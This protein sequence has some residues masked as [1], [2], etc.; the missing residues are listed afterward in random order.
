MTS[1][2]NICNKT[3]NAAIMKFPCCLSN[4]I[5]NLWFQSLACLTDI[6][7]VKL[8]LWETAPLRNCPITLTAKKS[9]TKCWS[10]LTVDTYLNNLIRAIVNQAI[11]CTRCLL[12]YYLAM[13]LILPSM[14]NTWQIDRHKLSKICVK[15]ILIK[16]NKNCLILLLWGRNKA[17]KF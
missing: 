11:L 15:K 14:G 3:S 7:G 16:V 6:S 8:P 10:K 13:G 4:V 5:L 9:S 1:K 12:R 2:Q 17:L